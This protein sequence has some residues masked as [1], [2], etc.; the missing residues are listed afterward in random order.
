MSLDTYAYMISC[1]MQALTR[2]DIAKFYTNYF[3]DG[4]VRTLTAVIK[5]DSDP[6]EYSTYHT[7][8]SDL[9]LYPIWSDKMEVMHHNK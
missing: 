8:T 1:S 4:E 9:V 3:L 7:N 6:A 5:S 2:E